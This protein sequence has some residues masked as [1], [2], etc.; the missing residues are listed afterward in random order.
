MGRPSRGVTTRPYRRQ[1]HLS[2]PRKAYG[3]RWKAETLI[4]VVKRRFGGA[5]TARRSWQQ[6]KPTL[7]GGMP[8]NLD[9]AVQLGLSVHLR[10]HRL[11]Q[12]AA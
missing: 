7:L 5:V 12:A 8:S 6:V 2:F 3:Q 10:S 4:S 11:F 9:R 1:L